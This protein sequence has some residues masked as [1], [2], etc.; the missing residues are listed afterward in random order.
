MAVKYQKVDPQ[1]DL[2][3]VYKEHMQPFIQDLF[4]WDEQFQKQ[5]FSR[6]LR[7][8]DFRWVIIDDV[9][10]GIIHRQAENENIKI[11]LL[12]IFRQFQ[13][14]GYGYRLMTSLVDST[15]AGKTLTWNCLKNNVPAL[16]LYDK[17][18]A[19]ERTETDYFYCYT[20]Q[21]PRL[22]RNQ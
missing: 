7:R 12:V 1:M 3:E 14:R 8:E 13:R 5:G 15:G 4:G 21:N 16:A 10:A 17:I 2:F 9:K 19:T 20:Y 6:A 11:S 22:V 18:E